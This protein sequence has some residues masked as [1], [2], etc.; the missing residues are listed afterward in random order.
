M[1]EGVE[2]EGLGEKVGKKRGKRLSSVHSSY[3]MRWRADAEVAPARVEMQK[4]QKGK[5]KKNEGERTRARARLD[6]HV[7]RRAHAGPLCSVRV[8]AR[9]HE[10]KLALAR[11][12]ARN[13]HKNALSQMRASEHPPRTRKHSYASSPA[14]MHAHTLTCTHSHAGPFARTHMRVG[15]WSRQHTPSHVPTRTRM[16]TRAKESTLESTRLPL[17]VD[18][19]LKPVFLLLKSRFFPPFFVIF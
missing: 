9:S 18:A 10:N 12:H 13:C 1:E 19:A 3:L 2:E 15:V 14:H 16:L 11:S 6:S 4:L 5:V 7:N 8:R 17:A